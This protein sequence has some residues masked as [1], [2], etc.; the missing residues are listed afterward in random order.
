[1]LLQ[2]DGGTRR[3][4]SG[5]PESPT[6]C[7]ATSSAAQLGAYDAVAGGALDSDLAESH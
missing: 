5:I 2:T 7:C 1:V 6:R 3:A 4:I